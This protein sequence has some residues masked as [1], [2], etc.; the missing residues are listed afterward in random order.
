VFA[1]GRGSWWAVFIVRRGPVGA[2]SGLLSSFV[3]A[4]SWGGAGPC[5]LFVGWC[6]AIV[7]VPGVVLGRCWHSWGGAGSS[8]P[9]LGVV[10]GHSLGGWWW[11]LV[12]IRVDTLPLHS[13]IVVA[14]HPSLLCC[15]GSKSDDER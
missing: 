15:V 9:M 14:V 13:I 10:M 11:A 3:G 5:S 8:S 2:D 6:W 7:V 1:V 12:A 4:G